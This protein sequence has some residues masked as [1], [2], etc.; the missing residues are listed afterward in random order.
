MHTEHLESALQEPL[1]LRTAV[2]YQAISKD[3]CCSSNYCDEE[4]ESYRSCARESPS[5][6]LSE[7][8][9]AS[10]S[11][12]CVSEPLAAA[13][14]ETPL[15]QTN[16]AAAAATPSKNTAARVTE[17]SRRRCDNLSTVRFA[18]AVNWPGCES[19]TATAVVVRRT[20]SNPEGGAVVCEN[21]AIQ[22][23]DA[24]AWKCARRL[25]RRGS[26]FSGNWDAGIPPFSHPPDCCIMRWEGRC[27]FSF[28]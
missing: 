6:G 10:K 3:S 14:V 25:N 2:N 15:R 28:T 11:S 26:L 13:A 12:C 24:L 8:M 23:R 5:D 9:A 17:S 21:E 7:A 19:K 1:K 22:V 16:G 18:S 4:G 27:F 20:K